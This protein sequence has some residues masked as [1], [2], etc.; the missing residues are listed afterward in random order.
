MSSWDEAKQFCERRN[1]TLPIISDEQTDKLFQQFIV[2]GSLNGDVWIGAHARPFSTYD[3]FHWID[4]RLP[5]SR[6]HCYHSAGDMGLFM[7][8][9]HRSHGQDKTALS[10]S[11]TRRELATSPTTEN[12]ETVS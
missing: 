6:N 3:S 9:S 10:V 11:T 1:S 2:S 5:G 7:S 12:V 8:S 4:G